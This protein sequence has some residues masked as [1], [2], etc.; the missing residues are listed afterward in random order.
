M[1]KCA[2]EKMFKI[3]NHQKNAVQSAFELSTC[4]MRNGYSEE[5]NNNNNNTQKQ[6]EP[7]VGR[8]WRKGNPWVLWVGQ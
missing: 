3:R 1:A 7:V 4:C 5:N 6:A 8:L 2:Q